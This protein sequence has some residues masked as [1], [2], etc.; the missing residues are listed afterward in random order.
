MAAYANCTSTG[1]NMCLDKCPSH[2][3]IDISSNICSPCHDDCAILKC[4]EGS[5]NGNNQDKCTECKLMDKFL[6]G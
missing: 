5:V 6:S 4:I 3:I 2:T 1:I